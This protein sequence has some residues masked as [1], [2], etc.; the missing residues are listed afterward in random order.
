MIDQNFSLN[1]TIITIIQLFFINSLI[2]QLFFKFLKIL[3]YLKRRYQNI[4]RG[5]NNSINGGCDKY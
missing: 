4:I 1:Y 3:Q 2:I 5:V